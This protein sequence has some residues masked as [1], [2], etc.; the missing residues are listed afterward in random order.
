MP[1][2]FTN[3]SS[4]LLGCVDG[5]TCPNLDA[6]RVNCEPGCAG[7]ARSLAEFFNFLGQWRVLER[8]DL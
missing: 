6:V 7:L 3:Q 4:S 5:S 2:L 1:S 8:I